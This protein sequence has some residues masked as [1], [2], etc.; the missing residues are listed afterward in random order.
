MSE[1]DKLIA[2]LRAKIV[3]LKGIITELRLENQKKAAELENLRKMDEKKI[4]QITELEKD[5]QVRA[6]ED[7]DSL[8]EGTEGSPREEEGSG[9]GTRRDFP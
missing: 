6:R 8:F 4:K 5:R 3:K 9:F 7:G 2:K 1:T